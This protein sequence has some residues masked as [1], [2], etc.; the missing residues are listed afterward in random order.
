MYIYDIH[1]QQFNNES[2]DRL[3]DTPAIHPS[4]DVVIAISRVS[5]LIPFEIS[6]DYQTR[7]ITSGGPM[8]THLF[9]LFV[10]SEGH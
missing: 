5:E 9:P 4:M 2:I 10:E 8:P 1:I 6:H 7:P 3:R